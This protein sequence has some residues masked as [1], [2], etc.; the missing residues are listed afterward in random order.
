VPLWKRS[1]GEYP[2]VIS[3]AFPVTSPMIV[4][5]SQSSQVS[6]PF[7]ASSKSTVLAPSGGSG[8]FSV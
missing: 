8:W 1:L 2:K 4:S 3:A 6:F 7:P 5:W